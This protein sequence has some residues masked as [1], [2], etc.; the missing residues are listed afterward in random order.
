MGEKA[1]YY[2]SQYYSFERPISQKSLEDKW[3]LQ[4]S[5]STKV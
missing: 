1:L 2:T 5:G 4:V 3:S